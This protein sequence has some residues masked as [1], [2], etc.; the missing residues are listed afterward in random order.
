MVVHRCGGSL[1]A[2]RVE[3]DAMTKVFRTIDE[4]DAFITKSK[5]ITGRSCGTCSL[6]CR[7]LDVPEAGK[8]DHEWCPHCRPGKGC[9]IYQT[10]PGK[11]R[12]YGCLWLVNPA[13]DDNWF[14][15]KCGI[16]G[17]VHQDGELDVPQVRF[18]VDPRTPNRWQEEPFYSK[19]KIIALQ[20]LRGGIVAGTMV[21]TIIY[22]K[23]KRILVLP[24]KDIP[25][26]PEIILRTGEFSYE[27]LPCKDEEA[28]K[29]TAET[30]GL[31]EKAA[32]EAGERARKKYG[33]LPDDPM[34][35]M[36][37]VGQDPEFIAVLENI[38]AAHPKLTRE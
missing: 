4:A 21:S 34:A 11:C 29:K 15:K 25:N 14:P 26:Q 24:N 37:L 35:A 10:R 20:G 27:L 19:I 28:A 30:L 1:C 36:N 33:C 12:G 17:D 7:L 32:S 5:T 13:F 16:V 23:E 8:L 22:I 3:H 31:F 2:G 9:L 6:C 18:I 38:A